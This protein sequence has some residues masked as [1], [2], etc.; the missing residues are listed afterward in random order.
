MPLAS[1]QAR[2]SRG[3]LTKAVYGRLFSK[4]VERCNDRLAVSEASAKQ[5][6]ATIGVLDIFGFESFVTNSFEQLCIN[7]ANEAL[8][9]HFCADVFRA[10]QAECALLIASDCF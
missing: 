7:Y 6:C 9:Q 8:Q 1:T 3:A 4:L 2:D 10:E 5:A